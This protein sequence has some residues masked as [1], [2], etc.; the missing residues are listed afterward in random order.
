MFKKL[1]ANLGDE[2]VNISRQVNTEEEWAA[3][4]KTKSWLEDDKQAKKDFIDE[5]REMHK[6]Y[7]GDHWSLKGPT[8]KQIRSAQTQATKPNSVDNIIF[9]QVEGFVAEFS[10]E[11]ELVCQPI[12]DGDDDNA[13]ALGELN[14]FLLIKNKFTDEQRKLL[15]YMFKYGPGIVQDYWD[16]SWQGGR[17]PNRWIGDI[18]NR[19]LHPDVLYIDARCKED[20]N[21][22]ER[23]HKVVRYPL[24]Y[25]KLNFPEKGQYVRED[26]SSVFE[27]VGDDDED[28]KSRRATTWLIETWYKGYPFIGENK[29]Y[30][31]HVLTWTDDVVLK[32][33]SY[34][35]P[36]PIYPFIFRNL[37]D[38][39]GSIWGFGEIKQI[40][41]PQ[42]I[43][44]KED[45]TILEG[46]MHQAFGQTFYQ[47]SAINP[48]QANGILAKGSIPGMWFPVQNADGIKRLYGTGVP[49]SVFSHREAKMQAIETIT[50]RYDTTQGR[51]PAG[52]TA[53]SAIMELNNRATN[54]MKAKEKILEAI[55]I[56]IGQ[57]NNNYIDWFYTE[58]RG[59][60]IL[61][62][63][64][65]Y[66][67]KEFSSEQIKKVY[68]F[69]DSKTVGYQEFAPGGL[70]EQSLP[71]G[72]TVKVAPNGMVE[73]DD[74]EVYSPEFDVSCKIGT[75]LP[76]G[77]AYYIE[78]S[79]E[80]F[81]SGIIDRRAVIYAIENGKLEPMEDIVKRMEES[82]PPPPGFPQG[83]ILPPGAK[84]SLSVSDEAFIHDMLM[85]TQQ[86]NQE[87]LT[88]LIAQLPSDI[89]QYVSQLPPNEQLTFLAQ[90]FQPEGGIGDG[91]INPG[92]EEGVGI[93]TV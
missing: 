11:P 27:T 2:N 64:N 4:Q 72:K 85:N 49:A 37:Y 57:R 25:F 56:E 86:S 3:L 51:V 76:V 38:R 24:N 65:K 84:L 17:G 91:N 18:R 5:M 89:Q 26:A 7:M 78:L 1:S 93:P 66:I 80:L 61:G 21:T 52:I 28:I 29:G 79:K 69:S 31:L 90:L 50:G 34:I 53:A 42:I 83:K 40:I 58:K 39:E 22:A 9:S 36:E 35:Y 75:E 30:G 62:K 15:R 68:I 20:I 48:K 43:L 82:A 14:K 74:F 13:S 23:V 32:H 60:R 45:E 77:R 55:Y 73:G 88:Q 59:Y 41:S 19:V 10:I 33:Q 54:R 70:T 16:P 44:N 87:Q 92:A 46:N 81:T 47:E 6:A 63:D 12:E 71:E 67:Q 8:G